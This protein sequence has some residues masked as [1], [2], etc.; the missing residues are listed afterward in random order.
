MTNRGPIRL[1]DSGWAGELE[2]AIRAEPNEVRIVCPFI[3][4]GA[5][6]PLLSLR[7]SGVRVVTRFNLVDFAEGVS[8]LEALKKLLDA[9]ASIRGIQNLH[10]KLYLFGSSRAIITSA[11]LTQAALTRNQEFGV[12]AEDAAIIA[13][14]Q[15][16]FDGLWR[17]SGSDVSR[18]MLDSWTETITAHLAVG[19]R[20]NLVEE[21]ADFGADA[22]V[23]V[24]T[25]IS[26]PAVVADAEQAFVKF[27]GK[28]DDRVPVSCTTIEEIEGTGCHWAVAY[29]SNRRPR[30]VKDGAVMFI[31]RFT[32]ERDIRVFGRAIGMTHQPGRDDA[33]PED[34]VLHPWKDQWPRYIRVHHAEFI[35]GT[36]A[37]GVSL[38]E[39]MDTLGSDSFAPT[40]INASLGI[41]NTD[42]R[43]AYIR[44]AAVELSPQGFSWLSEHL[45]AAFDEHGKVPQ[46]TLEQLDWPTLPDAG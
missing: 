2:K 10:A 14:C 36:M 46:D 8:D 42:P 7:P 37:N 28:G 23:S 1:V 16:Y 40:Q 17:R 4:K 5:L 35:A 13:A 27:I 33:T 43:R 12:V 41:G 9:G 38:N 20:P 30:S 22:G 11:N 32:D 26:L 31:A 44:Q 19:G 21:L 39:L 15:D 3:K 6:K 29:P 25:P 18:D 34:I 24:S 45:Q